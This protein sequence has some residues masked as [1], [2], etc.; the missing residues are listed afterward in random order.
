MVSEEEDIQKLKRR[1]IF[2]S[3]VF[4]LFVGLFSYFF[5]GPVDIDK[6]RHFPIFPGENAGRVAQ[7]LERGG[8]IRS[9]IVFMLLLKLNKATTDIKAG[10]YSFSRDNIFSIVRK[11]I[12]G[13]TL[14]L[15]VTIPEGF[16]AGQIAELLEE[17][18][19][20]ASAEFQAAVQERI[21]EGFLFPETYFFEPSTRPERIIQV[22][23][24]EFW[25]NCTFGM[26]RRARDL[27]MSIQQIVTLASLV[28][29]EAKLPEERPLVSAV[30]HNRLKKH[31]YLESCASVQY[32]QGKWKERLTYQDL[33]IKSPYNT[34]RHY[35]LPPGPIANPGLAS[36]QAALYPADSDA[37]FFVANSSGTHTF[38]RYYAEHLRTKKLVH[39][40]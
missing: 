17:R 11:L 40:P 28:E 3:A 7:R 14:R 8:F 30:F 12:R 39:S 6:D 4:L 16:S 33:A 36:L 32:A 22:M 1:A 18:G 5:L 24:K 2:I 27:G 20:C 31:W 10:T 35:G 25:R 34:Y 19:V 23:R 9:K 26:Q 21:S 15:K 37:L 38:S 13:E 29:R